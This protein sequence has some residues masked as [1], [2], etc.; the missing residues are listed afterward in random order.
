MIE[1]IV[2]IEFLKNILDIKTTL[3]N[4]QIY[5]KQSDNIYFD[6]PLKQIDFLNKTS[7]DQNKNNP[8]DQNKILN[9]NKFFDIDENVISAKNVLIKEI[10]GETIYSKNIEEKKPIASITKLMTALI[11]FENYKNL[12]E[13]IKISEKIFENKSILENHT[14]L[15]NGDVMTLED[16]LNISLISSSNIAS[17]AI[18]ENLGIEK[19]IELMNNKAKELNLK[20]TQF[21]D[22]IGISPQN[23]STL[24]DLSVLTEYILKEYPL[25]FEFSIK[26]AFNIDKNRIVYNTNHLIEKYKKYII[27]SKT[28]FTEEAAGCLIM[29]VKINNSPIIFVGVLGSRNREADAEYILKKLIDYYK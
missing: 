12:K 26:P 16:L 3:L 11:T 10:N 22:P 5:N 18:A 25:I 14:G 9:K 4:A 7:K 15:K 17:L 29:L 2:L 13:K 28:G 21:Q 19:F 20:D 1:L 27:G 23:V 6:Y 8:N 24:K